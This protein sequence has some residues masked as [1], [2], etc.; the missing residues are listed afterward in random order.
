ME[1]ESKNAANVDDIDELYE[2]DRVEQSDTK[3]AGEG[4]PSEDSDTSGSPDSRWGSQSR[5]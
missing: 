3:R 5:R 4:R 1:E 2:E